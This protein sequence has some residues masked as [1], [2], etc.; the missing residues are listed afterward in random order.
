MSFIKLKN[1]K[2]IERSEGQFPGNKSDK[3]KGCK[4]TDKNVF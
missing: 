2:M 4:N 1:Y 3:Y